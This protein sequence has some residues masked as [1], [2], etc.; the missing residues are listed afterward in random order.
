[1][2]REFINP[3]YRRVFIVCSGNDFCSSGQRVRQLLMDGSVAKVRAALKVW[4]SSGLWVCFV[5]WD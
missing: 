4:K 1:M 5:V 3:Q 2:Y